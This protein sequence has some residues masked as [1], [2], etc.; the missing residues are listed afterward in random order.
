MIVCRHEAKLRLSE[1]YISQ[2]KEYIDRNQL[3]PNRI[4]VQIQRR[5]LRE[6]GYSGNQKC[7]DQYRNIII[8]LPTEV[9]KE[10]FFLR[11]NDELFKPE[12]ESFGKKI[13]IELAPFHESEAFSQFKALKSFTDIPLNGKS[14]YFIV[15][16]PST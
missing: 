8:N 3:H 6:C 16:V 9:R 13:N 12:I 2:T 7:Q 11:S 1:D 14:G 5:A 10:I 4:D 15:A